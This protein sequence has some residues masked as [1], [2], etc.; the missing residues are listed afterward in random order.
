MKESLRMLLKENKGEVLNV[1]V[2]AKNAKM[3]ELGEKENDM[4]SRME[5]KCRTC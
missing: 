2:T 1:E 4:F 3:L 5:D